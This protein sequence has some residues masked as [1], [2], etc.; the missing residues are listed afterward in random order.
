[1]P[2]STRRWTGLRPSRTSG[3]RAPHDHA[4]RVIEV[5]RPHLLLE[6]ARLDV[7]AGQCVYACHQFSS[8]YTSRLVTLRALASMNSRRGSTLSPISIEKMR[9]AAD[10]VVDG[11]LLERP[12]LGVHRRVEELV[13]VH[14]AEALEALDLHALAR[15]VEHLA[16]QLLERQGRLLLLAERDVERRRAG[17]LLELLVHAHEAAVLGLVEHVP[18]QLVRRGRSGQPLDH[19]H[20]ELVAVAAQQLG[21]VRLA[22]GRVLARAASSP[23]RLGRHPSRGSATPRGR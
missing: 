21:L 15:D 12:P 22:L 8:S 16:A 18:A 14:L 13:G 7:A 4:H 6:P 19:A 11:H 1:M 23:R 20:D 3:Q 10:G 9:S 2:Y 17:E 5:R